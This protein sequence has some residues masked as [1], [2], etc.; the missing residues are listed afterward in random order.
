MM[1]MEYC[2]KHDRHFDVKEADFGMCT[3][4]DF[5]LAE[6]LDTFKYL[7]SKIAGEQPPVKLQEEFCDLDFDHRSIAIKSLYKDVKMAAI[8]DRP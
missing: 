8:G 1:S 2:H 3:E 4:C 5:E 6:H 7:V